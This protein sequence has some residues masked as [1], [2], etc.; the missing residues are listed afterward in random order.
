MSEFANSR[1]AAGRPLV[2]RGLRISYHSAAVLAA[3]MDWFLI[4]IS[5]LVGN[6]LYK[7][8]WRYGAE[9]LNTSLG[10]GA[11]GGILFL[12]LANYFKLYHLPA[13]LKPERY[14]QNMIFSLLV[15]CVLLTFVLFLLHI[16]SDVPRIMVVYFTILVIMT[17]IPARLLFGKVLNIF[18]IEGAL[19]GRR[20]VLIGEE[21]E[22]DRLTPAKLLI[23]F[24]FQEVSRILIPTFVDLA[25]GSEADEKVAYAIRVAREKGAEE[26]LV[27]IA[28]NR[29]DLLQRVNAGLRASTLPVRL[30][31][32]Q[33]VSTMM[34]EQLVSAHGPMVSIELQRAPLSSFQRRAKRSLDLTLATIAVMLLWPIMAMAAFAV[35]FD[36]S[37]PILFWQQRTGFDGDRFKICKFRTMS[38]LEDGADV[39]QAKP[40]DNRVTRVGAFLRR[41]S[42]DEL[43]QLFNVLRGDMSLVGP[44]PHA[45]SHDQEY[46]E[47]ISK[48]ASR[49]HV[50]PGITGWAQVN[51]LRGETARLEEM[52]RRIEF[53]LWYINN[54]SFG[55]DLW[56]L[57]RTSFEVVRHKAY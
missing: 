48:Y 36:T 2:T 55:L 18:F 26:L 40:G 44:R 46:R 9:T 39:V 47:L 35:R 51:G 21:A 25:R 15:M 20:A 14:L 5:G 6:V 31:P 54:W 33:I 53:D 56:I 50:K 17:L 32:D 22:L 27:A 12:F 11:V 4:A 43:P 41:T 30:L 28:W 37:G 45:L 34:G 7:S 24:G 38:V 1:I 29:V 13:L 3:A 42:I 10:I 23:W 8:V 52:E 16:G 49:F 57:L 19:V